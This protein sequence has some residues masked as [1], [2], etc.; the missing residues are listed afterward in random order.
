MTRPFETSETPTFEPPWRIRKE[1]L[2]PSFVF[3][4]CRASFVVSGKTEVE[5]LIVIVF[6]ACAAPAGSTAKNAETARTAARLLLLVDT[7][8]PFGLM[9]GPR[10]C[11]GGGVGRCDQRV[12]NL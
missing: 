5:P 4:H 6:F 7:P 12:T 3:T 8:T 2:S 1:N 9:R 11:V 10:Q